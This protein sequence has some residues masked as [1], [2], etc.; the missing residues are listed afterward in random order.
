MSVAKATAVFLTTYFALLMIDSSVFFMWFLILLWGD[1]LY[2]NV[3]I[4][5]SV[6][7]SCLAIPLT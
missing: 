5:R 6:S 3:T 2:I 1:Y 4:E 7:E